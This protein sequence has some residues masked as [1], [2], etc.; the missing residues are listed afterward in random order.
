MLGKLW[1][2]SHYILL[3]ILNLPLNTEKQL[4]D[5]R[6]KEAKT[7]PTNT[8]KQPTARIDEEATKMTATNTQKQLAH[9]TTPVNRHHISA[10]PNTACRP[11]HKNTVSIKPTRAPPILGCF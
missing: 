2:G 5:N 11:L 4:M 7:S 8:L 1:I 9:S 10:A 6:D 3:S